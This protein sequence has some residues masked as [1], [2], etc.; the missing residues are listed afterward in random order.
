MGK[1]IFETLMGAV[2]LVVALGFVSIAYN[3]GNV[4]KIDGYSLSARFDRIDGLSIG[5]DVR[6][7]GIKVGTI[8]NLEVDTKTFSAIAKISVD[9]RFKLP[10]D[11]LAEIVSE[12]LL[13]GKYLSLVPGADEKILGD[14]DE[15]KYTQSSINLEQ[16]VSKFAFGSAGDDS[17]GEEKNKKVGDDVED[18]F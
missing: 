17:S 14:G 4:S 15:I 16:L 5:S 12:S 1:N 7:S 13:G 3:S 10:K 8:T 18:I 11:T 2:V 6:I 9:D